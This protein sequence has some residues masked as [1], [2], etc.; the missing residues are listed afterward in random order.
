MTTDLK[1]AKTAELVALY[2]QL[3]GKHIR[4]H[5]VEPSDHSTRQRAGCVPKITL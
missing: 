5:T 2:N 1:A 4:M 3:T